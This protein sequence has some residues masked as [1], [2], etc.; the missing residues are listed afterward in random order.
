[1]ADANAA[2]S[3]EE[4]DDRPVVL[5][6]TVGGSPQPIATA[7]RLLRPKV[8]L[9]LVSDGRANE[10][11][12]SQV[13]STKIEYDRASGVYGPGLKFAEGCPATVDILPLP[14]DDPD[15]TY[16]LCR[17]HLANARRQYAGHRLIAD[18]TGG[19]KSM[20][21]ALLM[22][23][24]GQPG[25]EVQF[26]LGERPDLVQVKSGSEQPQRMATDFIMAE[27]DFAAAERAV[28]GYDYAAAQLLLQALRDRLR[29]V[30]TKP[31]KAFRRRLDRA[32]VW[33]GVM[34]DWDAFR[35]REA[36][37]RACREAWLREELEQSG[38]L[39]T[40][41]ALGRREKQAEWVACADLW[42][43]ALR[44]GEQGR[45]D[46]A[47]ARLYRLLEAVAQA[48]LWG[49]YRL[50][51]GRIAPAELPGSMR[52]SVFVRK[53][54]ENGMEFAQLALHQT[55]QLLHARDPHDE[56]AGAYAGGGASDNGLEGPRWLA[57]RNNSILAHGFVS[58]DRHAWGEARSWIEISRQAVLPQG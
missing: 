5:I 39:E 57:R 24:F 11:S 51:T 47:V 25:V 2:S 10:S 37:E 17:S 38:H 29:N 23:A 33:T 15:R 41:V 35:H 45:Y 14:A 31:P 9:F 26:M 27:R 19:T 54:P 12:R 46:D 16:A 55:V 22:A 53:D 58:I 7:L 52:A 42:L 21:A 20:S 49:R 8:V 4:R 32:L 3:V 28:D 44:R 34:S 43:N 50:E 13:D 36:T 18:Y 48:Q 56:F 6:C 30:E 1:M 40:L